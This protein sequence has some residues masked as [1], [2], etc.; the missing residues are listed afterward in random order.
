MDRLDYNNK[1]HKESSPSA[2]EPPLVEELDC[3]GDPNV[4]E[5]LVPTWE[6]ERIKESKIPYPSTEMPETSIGG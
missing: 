6:H 2:F 5:I 4:W 3:H 1:I